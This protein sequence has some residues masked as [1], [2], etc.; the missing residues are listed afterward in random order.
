[1][2]EKLVTFINKNSRIVKTQFSTYDIIINRIVVSKRVSFGK[3]GFK[4]FIEYENDYEEV[5]PLCIM[6]PKRIAC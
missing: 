1:M 4:Y 6:F 5:V 2:D 3:K